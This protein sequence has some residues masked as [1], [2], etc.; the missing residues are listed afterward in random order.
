MVLHILIFVSLD[1]R[2]EGKSSDL[3]NRIYRIEYT[4][5]TV[6]KYTLR[7]S[8]YCIIRGSLL[9]LRKHVGIQNDMKF[10]DYLKTDDPSV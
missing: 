6:E 3:L 8:K 7:F 2:K 1:G 5:L 9:D 10:I 4:E